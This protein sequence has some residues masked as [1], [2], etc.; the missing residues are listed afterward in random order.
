MASSGTWG[1]ASIIKGSAPAD[2][3][4]LADADQDW[5]RR[6]DIGQGAPLADAARPGNRPDHRNGCVIPV[7]IEARRLEHR[8]IA[9]RPATPVAAPRFA[10]DAGGVST[11]DRTR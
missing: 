3:L 10:L 9:R 4:D 8:W 6:R 1:M 5:R 11:H 7:V 2:H